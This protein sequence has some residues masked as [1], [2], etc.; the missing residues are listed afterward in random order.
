[1][2]HIYYFFTLAALMWEVSTLLET[3]R[4]HNFL[5]NF[6]E[7]KGKSWDDWTS[8]QKSYTICVWGYLCWQFV[9]LFTFQWPVFLVLHIDGICTQKAHRFKMG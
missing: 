6:R 3:R 7:H 4:V 2:K 5:T 1:M 8:T 9:G